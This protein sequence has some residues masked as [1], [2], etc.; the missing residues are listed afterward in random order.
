MG[1][2][3]HVS[4]KSAEDSTENPS[5]S[6]PLIRDV[7]INVLSF[8]N[9][10]NPLLI[11]AIKSAEKIVSF[12]KDGAVILCSVQFIERYVW[13]CGNR[14]IGSQ[15][16]AF[17]V[18]SQEIANTLKI[19]GKRVENI[20]HTYLDMRK[21]CAK[22]ETNNRSYFKRIRDNGETVYLMCDIH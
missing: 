21:L 1:T 6:R 2:I 14:T 10:Y 5:A 11:Y 4:T 9:K 16:I 15:V 13:K 17:T 20:M 18:K 8:I 3:H 12:L 7:I 19:P 22:W